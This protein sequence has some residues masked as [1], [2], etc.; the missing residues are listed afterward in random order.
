MPMTLNDV[1]TGNRICVWGRNPTI[2]TGYEELT[3]YAQA[4]DWYTILGAG[5]KI[6][7]TSASTADIMTSGT[8]AW[9][10]RIC[11][12]SAD[13]A[14]QSEVLALNGRTIVTSSLTYTDVFGAEVAAHGTGRTNA[15][16]L[17]MVKTGT[18]GSYTN[19]VPGTLTSALIKIVAGANTEMVGH[20]KVPTGSCSYRLRRLCASAYTQSAYINVCVATPGETD[21][22][23]HIANVF[24]LGSAGAIA[25][26]FG[27][28]GLILAA[29][30]ALILRA[31]GA[32]ASAAVQADFLLEAI[33]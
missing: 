21:K 2:T 18:G 3:G 31:Y 13:G 16:D 11:G 20:F 12:L 24:G 19:G 7:V 6:D 22:S 27:T 32:A 29:G 25:L 23:N 8:G 30:D 9:R 10:V 1:L 4:T 28:D 17:H 14:Y 5:A 26:D 33:R 15:G